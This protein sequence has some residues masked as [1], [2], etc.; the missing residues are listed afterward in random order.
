MDYT[1]T[2]VFGYKSNLIHYIYYKILIYYKS[3]VSMITWNIVIELVHY[4]LF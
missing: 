3:L 4:V 2:N 1:I